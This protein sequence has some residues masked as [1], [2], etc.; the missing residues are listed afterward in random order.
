MNQKNHSFDEREVLHELAHFLPAQ[1]PLKDFIHHNTLHAFQDRNFFEA[2]RDAYNSLGYKTCLSL[3][4]YRKLYQMGKIKPKVLKA[5]L[6]KQNNGKPIEYWMNVLLEKTPEIPH[7]PRLGNVRNNWKTHY[8]IDLDSLVFPLFFRLICSYLDQGISI[9]NFPVHEKGLI[10]SLRELERNSLVSLFKSQRAKDLLFDD[11]KT[12]TD[13]L[14]ILVGKEELYEHYLFDQQF[15]HQGWSGMVA[16]IESNPQTLLDKKEITLRDFIFLEL[17]VEIN[18]LDEHFGD[19]WA[20]VGSKIMGQIVPLFGI[21]EATELD[22]AVQIWQ[23]AFEWSFYDSVLIGIQ[24]NSFESSAIQEQK[25]MQAIFCIDD[26]ECSLRRHLEHQD[27]NIET[28]GTP[29]F[30]NVEFYFQ[31]EHGKFYEKVCPAPVNPKYLI[32]EEEGHGHGKKDPHFNKHAHSL[33]FGWLIAQTL[34][35]WSAFKLLLNLFVPKGSPAAASSFKHM[36]HS[37]KL[38]IE[39]DANPKFENGL[40]VGFTVAEMAQ[41]V[42]SLLRSIGLVEQFSN[43]VY[44][45]GHGSSSINNPYYA[46]YDCGACS[47]R[48]GS[49]NAR[50]FCFMANHPEVR[51]MLKNDGLIIPETTL[52]VGA[53]HDTASDEIVFYDESRIISLYASEHVFNKS[54]FQNAL[55]INAKERSRRLASTS[56][57]GSAKEVHERMKKRVVSLFEP[58]PEL[59]HAT[60]ALCIIGRRSLSNHLFLDRRAFMNSYNYQIDPSG[61]ILLSII[62]PAAPV[63]GGINLEYYFSRVDNHKLGA[64]TKLPQNVMG[65]FGLANGSDGD[66]RPG[67]PSQMIEMHDPLRLLMIVE[68]YPEIVLDVIQRE[69]ATFEWFKNNWI[70]LIAVHPETKQLFYFENGLFEPYQTIGEP[71]KKIKNLEDLYT[72]TDD[73]LEIMEM[74]VMHG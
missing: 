64:G 47:G 7:K 63:C 20:P 56:T 37:S 5:V 6:A 42:K 70:N 32:K 13:L 71:L 50:V 46:A 33:F 74:E 39:A 4:E 27:E 38:K 14:A 36:D 59:N 35:P 48:P 61:D 17:L 23:L 12:I 62:R 58:R 3:Y 9:W 28:F 54:C 18:V 16:Q 34:G 31:P 30:F 15:S 10:A 11:Q 1:A 21:Q 45:V 49:V 57:I 2:C 60:N 44:V 66:L 69:A 40:Q 43:I 29:G 41:R 22:R 72:T 65:L 68:H 8:K 26:R 52:F 19:I 73:N 53:L 51:K 55:S 67:L 24:Q 25:K